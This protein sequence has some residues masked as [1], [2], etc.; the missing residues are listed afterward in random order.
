MAEKIR[1]ALAEYDARLAQRGPRGGGPTT[2]EVAGAG[3]TLAEAIR[4]ALDPEREL[5]AE[6]RRRGLLR[7]GGEL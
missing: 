3:R 2:S 6:C 4:V 5:I 1:E 7:E